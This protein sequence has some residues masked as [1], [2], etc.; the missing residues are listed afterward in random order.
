MLRGGAK[1]TR[2]G[3]L[4]FWAKERL[5]C[6]WGCWELCLSWILHPL[7]RALVS[8]ALHESPKATWRASWLKE[9]QRFP[10]EPPAQRV[11]SSSPSARYSLGL[12]RTGCWS[13]SWHAA[14][15]LPPWISWGRFSPG[16]LWGSEAEGE[17]HKGQHPRLLF[18]SQA[19]KGQYTQFTSQAFKGRLPHSC[20][21]LLCH[22]GCCFA[23]T[24]VGS[25][26]GTL[27]SHLWGNRGPCSV[28]EPAVVAAPPPP[29]PVHRESPQFPDSGSG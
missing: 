3:I 17:A 29:Q 27:W 13:L 7:C 25:T 15:L 22:R 14:L 6:H 1:H 16:S 12:N 26:S 24:G 8:P 19:F 21:Q 20:S 2:G 28:Q 18:T 5:P 23:P 4:H 10:W 11:S 9:E